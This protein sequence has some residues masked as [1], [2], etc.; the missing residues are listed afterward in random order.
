M[1]TNIDIDDALMAAA[2]KASGLRTKRATVEEAL[3]LLIK[4]ARQ[5]DVAR[6]AGKVKWEGDL[7]SSR[8]GRGAA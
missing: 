7:A 6:L 5:K 2:L 1:R 4:L 8:L 3:R